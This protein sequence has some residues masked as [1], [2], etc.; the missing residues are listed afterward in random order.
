MKKRIDTVLMYV[1]YFYSALCIAS[2]FTCEF[3]LFHWGIY[4][5]VNDLTFIKIFENRDIAYQ[6]TQCKRLY[7]DYLQFLILGILVAIRYV[8]SGKTYQR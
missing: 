2:I 7:I 6:G 4:D 8:F 5:F 3:L 1:I